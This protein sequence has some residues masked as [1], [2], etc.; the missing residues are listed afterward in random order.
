MIAIDD[1]IDIL[2]VSLPT[3]FLNGNASD[4]N[5]IASRNRSGTAGNNSYTIAQVS[6][7][8]KCF[9]CA[10][11]CLVYRLRDGNKLC[12]TP[13][14]ALFEG[15]FLRAHA[16]LYTTAFAGW[17]ALGLPRFF[18]VAALPAYELVAVCPRR[19]GTPAPPSFSC[20]TL[21]APRSTPSRSTPYAVPR[22]LDAPRALPTL[23]ASPPGL[24]AGLF[25]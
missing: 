2:G 14:D 15:K 24:T 18:T 23:M 17:T 5:N 10:S 9:L 8:H 22:A 19:A 13:V 20:F 1:H 12:R 16:S 11:T 4:N 25:S 3:Q 7:V 6:R 21:F